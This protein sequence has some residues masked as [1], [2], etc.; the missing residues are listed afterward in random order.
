MQ[1]GRPWGSAY[2]AVVFLV[3]ILLASKASFASSGRIFIRGPSGLIADP[4]L[5]EAI[6]LA[7]D[8][9]LYALDQTGNLS[10]YYPYFET[11]PN[12]SLSLSGYSP[13][14]ESLNVGGDSMTYA[15]EV[16]TLYIANLMTG[17]MVAVSTA[18]SY[19][20][21]TIVT[22]PQVVANITMPYPTFLN[23]LEGN[24][25]YLLDG[26]DYNNGNANITEINV[27]TNAIITTVGIPLGSLTYSIAC[28]DNGDVFLGGYEG[29]AMVNVTAGTSTWIYTWSGP[30]VS[31]PVAF[32]Q[33]NGLV[34]TILGDNVIAINPGTATVVANMSFPQG[35]NPSAM[36]VDA[37][38]NLIF[39]GLATNQVDVIDGSSNTVIS[40][41]PTSGV[42][43]PYPVAFAVDPVHRV[44]YTCFLQ[45][46]V[47]VNSFF[48]EGVVT[49]TLT[50][51]AT[52]SLHS[53]SVLTERTTATV[54][55]VSL[56][57]TTATVATTYTQTSAK[58]LNQTSVRTTAP[59]SLGTFALIGALGTVSALVLVETIYILRG[60]L[61]RH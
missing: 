46:A 17:R 19:T 8:G 30:P 13:L 29:V 15:P 59:S 11:L 41:I 22:P 34:Y 20:N 18:V 40:S 58:I 12:G 27:S 49:Q 14:N 21:G 33:S 56:S 51:T 31:G 45:G 2:T 57:T 55:L 60:R 28:G 5:P 61:S 9:R 44:L 52:T 37:S 47:Q 3:I 54:V 23:C 10:V 7:Q 25:L 53:T 6:A 16:N 39:L 38:D 42:S 43:S 50:R 4:G 48:L 35:S 1:K 24:I 36:Q 32:D 26:Y